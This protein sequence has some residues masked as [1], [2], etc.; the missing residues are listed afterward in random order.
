MNRVHQS[1]CARFSRVAKAVSGGMFLFAAGWP[2]VLHT[3]EHLPAR[4]LQVIMD[5]KTVPGPGSI[6]Y[7]LRDLQGNVDLE[8]WLA[9]VIFLALGVFADVLRWIISRGRQKIN[10]RTVI[11]PVILGGI[12]ALI[13]WYQIGR[14]GSE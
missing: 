14:Y 3:A 10:Y 1:L 9:G 6:R 11:I 12:A 4:I 2:I 5:L 8:F 7:F 13:I